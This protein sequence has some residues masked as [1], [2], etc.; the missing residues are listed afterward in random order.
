MPN[1]DEHV[2]G[3]EEYQLNNQQGGFGYT[4]G[5]NTTQGRTIQSGNTYVSEHTTQYGLESLTAESFLKDDGTP[6]PLNQVVRL[7]MQHKPWDD[8]MGITE[9]QYK[10]D[11]EAKVLDMMPK[12]QQVSQK[13]RGFLVSQYGLGGTEE[14]KRSLAMTKAKDAYGLSTRSAERGLGTALGQAQQQAGQ[15]GA[16]MRGGYGGMGGGMRGAIGGQASLAKGVESTYGGYQDKMLGAQQQ[17][18]YA[19]AEAGIRGSE[20]SRQYEKGLYG[21]EE[22]VKGEFEADIATFLQNFKK[23]GRVPSKQTFLDVLS[24]IPDAGGS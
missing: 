21:L 8:S 15:L 4:S 20:I 24:R 23:G 19:E 22:D 12:I 3:E 9:A 11:M 14:K 1:G 13:E 17:L 18:G 5:T 16:Q 10:K 6:K 2:Y 7:L